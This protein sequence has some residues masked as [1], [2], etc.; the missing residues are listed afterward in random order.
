MLKST[1]CQFTEL[2]TSID[3]DLGS[4]CESALELAHWGKSSSIDLSDRKSIDTLCAEFDE[5]RLR[6]TKGEPE[7]DGKTWFIKNDKGTYGMGIICAS[8][9]T[10]LGSKLRTNAG[11]DQLSYTKNK[12]RASAFIFQEG[13]ETNV[14]Y[15]GN[16][17]GPM[18][19]GAV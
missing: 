7:T 12:A 16:A 8:S 10:D 14:E 9:G 19:R 3:R 5:T 6:E 2:L 1:V 11:V 17:A 18:R 15:Q 4:L 13:I